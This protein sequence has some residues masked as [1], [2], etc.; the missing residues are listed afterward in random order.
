MTYSPLELA[1]RLRT[2]EA[3]GAV[4]KI[5]D[6]I[7]KEALLSFPVRTGTFTLTTD[8]SGVGVGA[9]LTQTQ[10]GIGRLIAFHSSLHSQAERNY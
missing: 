10:E 3:I 1:E 4:A 7:K 2:P 6:E 8:A 5:K 9:I